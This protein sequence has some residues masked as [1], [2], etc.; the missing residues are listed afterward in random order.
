MPMPNK[1]LMYKA[2]VQDGTYKGG[3]S[4]SQLLPTYA[5]LSS[6]RGR[7][8]GSMEIP[9]LRTALTRIQRANVWH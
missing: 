7:A 5:I 6:F 9:L 4:A 1:T 8:Q 2:T 3:Q